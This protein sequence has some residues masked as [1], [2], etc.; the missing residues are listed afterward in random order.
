MRYSAREIDLE[1][2]GRRKI[3]ISGF[4]RTETF[5]RSA[6]KRNDDPTV[7]KNPHDED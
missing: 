7:Q 6:A 3:S 4:K 1:E 5:G 2:L